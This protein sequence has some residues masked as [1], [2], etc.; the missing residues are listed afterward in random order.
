MHPF[1]KLIL[2]MRSQPNGISASAYDMAW[3][4]WLMPK[5]RDWLCEA[6]H[7][8]GSWGAELEYYHD[9]VVCTLAAVNAL[10]ATSNNG[11]DLK[12][13]ERGIKYLEGAAPRLSCDV[14]ETVGFELLAPSLLKI[15]EGLGLKLGEVSRALMPYEAIRRQKMALIPPAM[16]YSRKSTAPY[17]LEFLGFENLDR[18][19]VPGLRFKNGSIHN[20]PGATAFCEVAGAGSPA[21]RDYLSSTLEYYAGTVPT[22]APSEVFEIS[23]SLLHL[24]VAEELSQFKEVVR[25]LIEVLED[26]WGPEGAGLTKEFPADLDDT[27]AAYLLLA[28]LNKA[29]DPTAFE[30]FE[31]KDHFHCYPFERNISLDVHIHLVMA[32]RMAPNFPRRDD[33]LLKAINILNRYL[34]SEYITDKWHVSP[35]YSTA[36]AII[37]LTGLVNDLLIENQINWICRTQQ[38]DGSWTFYPH[39]PAA[40]LE[41]T[42]HALLAL[43]IFQKHSG[44]LPYD[45]IQRGMD[46]LRTHY[47]YHHD[48]PALWIAKTVYRP[49][50][51]TNAIFLATFSLYEQLYERVNN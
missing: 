14:M 35:Y 26:G 5:A 43:L 30:A 7:A 39:F 2:D 34:Q 9:R 44:S 38:A 21:G 23:W 31:E 37:A 50:H 19:A 8:D 51:I 32:L 36:H 15:G 16:L 40:A 47:H 10:A 24:S 12:R 4:A 49:L 46:F 28:T 20:S 48:R 45:I 22:F 29:P 18:S 6:Q 1:H 17:S 33:M 42:A 11:H 41:E 13:M 27:A 3:L 25:P